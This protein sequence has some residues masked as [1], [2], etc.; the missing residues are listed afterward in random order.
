MTCHGA[1]VGV[2]VRRGDLGLFIQ[3]AEGPKA[4][5]WAFP[6]GHQEAGEATGETAVREVFE[7][8]TLRI[9]QRQLILPRGHGLLA[10]ECR[11]GTAHHNWV[12]WEAEVP[13]GDPVRN[14]DET[15]DMRWV[16]L[17]EWGDLDLEP[18]WR[19]M[20]TATGHL[21]GEVT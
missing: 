15:L 1:S 8:V 19:R 20:L 13:T 4:G 18:V 12:T 7:E 5:T 2:I 10:D 9:N 17:A 21:N 16:P 11:H 3:R 14:E 6:A